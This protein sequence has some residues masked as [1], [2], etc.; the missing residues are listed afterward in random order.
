MYIAQWCLPLFTKIQQ[1]GLNRSRW[2]RS[3]HECIFS[4]IQ[5]IDYSELFP[6]SPRETRK[7]AWALKNLPV[8]ELSGLQTQHRTR[9][10]YYQV[11]REYQ[12]P[13]VSLKRLCRLGQ[14]VSIVLEAEIP[15]EPTEQKI[16]S[17]MSTAESTIQAWKYTNHEFSAVKERFVSNVRWRAFH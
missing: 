1:D 3:R 14:N 2:N 4:I 7:I 11:L 8:I 5:G 10:D 16:L 12:E 13:R 9:D 17:R 6:L 15:T